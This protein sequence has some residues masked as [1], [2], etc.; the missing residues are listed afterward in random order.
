MHDLL[1][2]SLII[3]SLILP[4]LVLIL[5]QIRKEKKTGG[6]AAQKSEDGMKAE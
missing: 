2:D 5:W 1:V 4:P 3:L 6:A